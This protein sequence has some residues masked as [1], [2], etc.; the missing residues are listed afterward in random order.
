MKP[1]DVEVQV[2]GDVLAIKADVTG[3]RAQ[4]RHLSRARTRYQSY[5]RALSLPTPLKA[6]KAQAEVKDGIQHVILP[7]AEEAKPKVITVK[8]T[9]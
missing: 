5:A 3:R 9:K 4:R 6:E 1:E 7:K 2:N 8:A